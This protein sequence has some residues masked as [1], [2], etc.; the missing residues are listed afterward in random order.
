MEKKKERITGLSPHKF[1]LVAVTF[2]PDNNRDRCMARY[3]INFQT[4]CV[5]GIQ[6]P[7]LR[8]RHN[9]TSVCLSSTTTVT[10]YPIKFG[11][12]QNSRLPIHARFT[13]PSVW[14]YIPSRKGIQK[15][16]TVKISHNVFCN[17]R[18]LFLST[19]DIFY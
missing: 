13:H 16:G 1:L 2:I 3:V 10:I 12:T 14:I 8:F 18:I 19:K 5:W 4:L 15:L 11:P 17:A 6:V 9:Y 7:Q